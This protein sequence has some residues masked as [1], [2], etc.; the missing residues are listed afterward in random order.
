MFPKIFS[1]W[2]FL[3]FSLCYLLRIEYVLLATAKKELIQ[4]NS[5]T[6][7]KAFKLYFLLILLKAKKI[8]LGKKVFTV[9][10]YTNPLAIGFLVI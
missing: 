8:T 4:I 6:L 10:T 7:L 9:E 1:V 3:V 2:C 5:K